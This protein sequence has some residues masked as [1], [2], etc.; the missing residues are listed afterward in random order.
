M[1]KGT[2]QSIHVIDNSIREQM[3]LFDRYGDN[4][5]S[6][7]ISLNHIRTRSCSAVPPARPTTA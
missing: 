4:F 5:F 3:Q 1:Q 6:D 2:S 7:T